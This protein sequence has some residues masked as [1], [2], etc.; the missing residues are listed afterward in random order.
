MES[1]MKYS[2]LRCGQNAWAKPGAKLLCGVCYEDSGTLV[3]M[4]ECGAK[5]G[6]ASA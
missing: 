1:K 5:G 2:C 3:S 4:Q 6:D